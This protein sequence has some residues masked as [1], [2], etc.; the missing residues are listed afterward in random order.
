MKFGT[1]STE[2]L[3]GLDLRL[4]SEH[5]DNAKF[6]KSSSQGKVFVGCAKWGRDEV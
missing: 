3:D 6:T 5:Q 2:E 1:V 4:Q